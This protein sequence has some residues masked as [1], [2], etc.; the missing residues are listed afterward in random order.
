MAYLVSV[1]LAGCSGAGGEA[2]IFD[3]PPPAFLPVG[4]ELRPHDL[5]FGIFQQRYRS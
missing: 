1:L 3:P 4:K 5:R 2:V